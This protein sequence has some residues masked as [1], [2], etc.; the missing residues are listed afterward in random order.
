VFFTAGCNEQVFSNP[1]KTGDIRAVV[2]EKKA[3]PLNSDSFQFRKNNITE[4][5]ANY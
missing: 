2:F 5:K 4:A 1:K 3:K